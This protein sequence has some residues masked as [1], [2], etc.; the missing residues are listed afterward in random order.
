MRSA[1]HC[2]L[3]RVLPSIVVKNRAVKSVFDCDHSWY[4]LRSKPGVGL[5][6]RRGEARLGT[7]N[8]S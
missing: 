6:V 3:R 7:H 2:V 8:R 1:N 4:E 5:R